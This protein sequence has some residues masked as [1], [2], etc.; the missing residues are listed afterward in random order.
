M[1]QSLTPPQNA[2]GERLTALADQLRSQGT[3]DNIILSTIHVENGIAPEES[4]ILDAEILRGI[5]DG[6][7]RF[8]PEPPG[9]K[10]KA[11][12]KTPQAAPVKPDG[13]AK[14]TI[15]DNAPAVINRPLC[16]RED[17]A[18]LATW[19]YIPVSYTHLT[20]PTILRV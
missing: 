9:G 20:L 5:A 4:R 1:M 13:K 2:T 8:L 14:V 17:R 12:K 18:Y 6:S 10:R 19:L 15:M 3:A 11:R 16:L 7:L